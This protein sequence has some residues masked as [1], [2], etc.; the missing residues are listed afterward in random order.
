MK[1]DLSLMSIDTINLALQTMLVSA[2]ATMTELRQ[3][4]TASQME[5]GKEVAEAAARKEK[6]DA[7]VQRKA[8]RD[9]KNGAASPT[10]PV[11]T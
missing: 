3:A 2:N 5:H 8:A 4:V 10:P 6:A 11:A 7:A 9:K 1:I